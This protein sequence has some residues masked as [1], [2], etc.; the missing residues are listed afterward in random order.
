LSVVAALM[1]F[2]SDRLFY[3]V[4]ALL[5]AMLLPFTL[6]NSRRVQRN[7]ALLTEGQI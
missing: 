3:L 1:N 5:S 4:L 2:N 6:R 7:V